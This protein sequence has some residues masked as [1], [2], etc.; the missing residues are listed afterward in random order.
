[1]SAKYIGLRLSLTNNESPPTKKLILQNKGNE[2]KFINLCS[3]NNFTATFL[4]NKPSKSSTLYNHS[5]SRF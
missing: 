2:N 1:M 3:M 4:A 5:S